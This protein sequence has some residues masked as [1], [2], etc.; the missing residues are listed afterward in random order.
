MGVYVPIQR[1]VKKETIT[2]TGALRTPVIQVLIHSGY[3]II[4]PKEM[5]TRNVNVY[6]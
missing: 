3:W 2:R 5:Y 6:E 4:Y 1:Y